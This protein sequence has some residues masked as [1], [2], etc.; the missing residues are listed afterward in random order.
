MNITHCKTNHIKNPIGYAMEQVSVSWI[1]ESDRSTRQAKAQVVVATDPNMENI[2]FSENTAQ[3]TGTKFPI[4]LRPC[5]RYYWTVQVWGNNGDTAVS[6]I[7]FFETGKRQSKLEGHWITPSWEDQS[8]S[9][10]IRKDLHIPAVR[11]ARL[12]ITGLGLYWLYFQKI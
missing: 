6:E 10:Y 7:N 8:I 9:P 1:A 5:T 11:K 12:Y 3:S 4:A 2:I